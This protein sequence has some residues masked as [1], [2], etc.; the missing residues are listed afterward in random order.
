MELAILL[1]TRIIF[2]QYL[3]LILS[4]TYIQYYYTGQK[5]VPAFMRGT[6]VS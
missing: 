6:V 5:Q 2:E 1:D 3:L 4:Y